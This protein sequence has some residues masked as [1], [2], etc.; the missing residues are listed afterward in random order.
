MPPIG[1]RRCSCE[2]LGAAAGADGAA[3]LRVL[4]PTAHGHRLRRDRRSRSSARRRR[5]RRARR[6][7]R[8][9]GRSLLR[10]R[11]TTTSSGGRGRSSTSWST[12]ITVRPGPHRARCRRHAAGPS[13]RQ[14]R[15]LQP[16]RGLASQLG[17]PR[18]GSSTGHGRTGGCARM[19]G[20]SSGSTASARPP[21]MS[22]GPG[23]GGRARRAVGPGDA[24]RAPPLSRSRVP[25]VTSPPTQ[26][27]DLLGRWSVSELGWA[28]ALTRAQYVAMAGIVVGVPG[29]RV[30][31]GRLRLQRCAR[32][33]DDRRR[34]A[35]APA[36]C[37]SVQRLVSRPRGR[38]R[39]SIL[40]RGRYTTPEQDG[41]KKTAPPTS[42]HPTQPPLTFA[43]AALTLRGQ[44]GRPRPPHRPASPA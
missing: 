14:R 8:R 25:A 40:P 13:R 37:G 16:L 3:A 27:Q 35:E 19:P 20:T 1:A 12:A 24:R 38:I 4:Q 2:A 22:A 41:S 36:N 26:R 10:G 23:A 33:D 39:R 42:P 5:S 21:S 44:A 18:A 29:T 9:R 6:W 43:R 28:G 11:Q 32:A 30:P 31:C 7:H 17:H 34:R 15:V